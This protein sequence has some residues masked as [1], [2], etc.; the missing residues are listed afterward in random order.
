MIHSIEDIRLP[1][2]L[3]TIA[4]LNGMKKHILSSTIASSKEFVPNSK[5]RK[6][7]RCTAS[8]NKEL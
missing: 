4:S 1:T 8:L 5:D 7:G 3:L 6:I 2:L